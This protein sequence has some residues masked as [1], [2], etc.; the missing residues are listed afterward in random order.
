V[1]IGDSVHILIEF[2]HFRN[3][4]MDSKEAAQAATM[5]LFIPCL[6]TSITTGL[7]FM[8]ISVS[9]LKPLNEF[10]IA[11]A[12]GVVMAF[13]LSMTLMPA[14]LSFVQGKPS[15][16]KQI[17]EEGYVARLTA[18]LT[19]HVF[20]FK[21][22]I[23]GTSVAL[24]LLGLVGASKLVVDSNF[25]NFF[26][27][28]NVLKTDLDYFI[29]Q[30]NG[31][32]FLEYIVDSGRSASEAA[33]GGVM[34][35]KF[36]QRVEAFE[37][38]LRLQPESGKTISLVDMIKKMNQSM[39][40]DD[41]A[42]FALP[43]SRQ[44]V[45]QYLLLY[46]NSG[47]EEDLTDM[48]THDERY[49]RVSQRLSHMSSNQMEAFMSKVRQKLDR[50]FPDLKIQLTGMPVLYTNM[51]SYIHSGIIKSFSIAIVSIGICFL[52][53]LR[54][55]KYGLLAL[56]PSLFPILIAAGLMGFMGINLNFVA[57]VTASVT[58]G[59]AVD[60]SI[61]ILT[62][63]IRGRTNGMTRKEAVHKAISETG[64]AL[65][66]T[67]LILFFGFSILMLSTFIPNIHLG[68]FAGVILML[69]L[70]ASLTLLPSV[71]FFKGDAP[72]KTPQPKP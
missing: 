68:F 13:I 49:M 29:D 58:F 35:P 25:I 60:D 45:A 26:K 70:A 12:I 55:F 63:Y 57:L 52:I 37:A 22:G 71:M 41:P 18:N 66:Y 7:G 32:V 28:D 1:G 39:H 30:Y 72:A 47:P 48:K 10:G 42:A 11:A 65:V 23:M 6:N 67:T 38:W 56:I 64:R 3:Q 9:R 62:R 51:D 5:D 27:S 24:V 59:I 36:L 44:L 61:H 40:D 50:D 20:R 43:D 69:A 31:G 14:I 46:A 2:Y 53:L 21:W 4:G 33:S 15:K 16:V 8:A 17:S 19:E 34:E 54:S